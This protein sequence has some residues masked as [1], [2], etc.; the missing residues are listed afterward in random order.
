MKNDMACIQA[1]RLM[2]VTLTE[3]EYKEGL[4]RYYNQE[5]ENFESVEAF[6]E[7]YTK[8]FME[9]CIRW[10]KAFEMMVENAVS[11]L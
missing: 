7:H 3:E 5:Q 2:N 11:T 10:D 4:E 1:T 9:D 8:P 6:E